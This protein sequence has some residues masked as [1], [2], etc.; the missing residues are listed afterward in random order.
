M[1]HDA[2]ARARALPHL[3]V[4]RIAALLDRTGEFAPRAQKRYDDTE[5][6]LVEIVECGYDSERGPRAI[7]G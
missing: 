6:I 2:L 4:P 5:L 3:R 1:G 7:R